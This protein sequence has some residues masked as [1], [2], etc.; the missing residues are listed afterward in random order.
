MHWRRKLHCRRPKHERQRAEWSF[1]SSHQRTHPTIAY[2]NNNPTTV[3]NQKTLP[4]LTERLLAC[5]GTFGALAWPRNHPCFYKYTCTTAGLLKKLGLGSPFGGNDATCHGDTHENPGLG[6]YQALVNPDKQYFYGLLPHRHL[7]YV[8]ASPDGITQKG[9]LLEMKC[10]Y[11]AFIR[12]N[13]AW[14][15]VAHYYTQ[16]QLNMEITGTEVAHFIQYSPPLI[17]KSKHPSTGKEHRVYEHD[18]DTILKHGHKDDMYVKPLLLKVTECTRNRAFI[19]ELM[20]RIRQLWR[21]VE[22]VYDDARL[23]LGWQRVLRDLDDDTHMHSVVAFMRMYQACRAHKWPL[24]D[25]ATTL[26]LSSTPIDMRACEKR[27]EPND[28]AA[29]EDGAHIENPARFLRNLKCVCDHLVKVGNVDT[30][31]TWWKR[32]HFML[33]QRKEGLGARRNKN[34]LL[35]AWQRAYRTFARDQA[36]PPPPPTNMTG[37][38]H[39]THNTTDTVENCVSRCFK[40]FFDLSSPLVDQLRMLFK[41]NDIA[42]RDTDTLDKRMRYQYDSMERKDLM[43]DTVENLDTFTLPQNMGECLYYRF[44]TYEYNPRKLRGDRRTHLNQAARTSSTQPYCQTRTMCTDKK[45]APLLS[46]STTN[47]IRTPPT[48]KVV[49]RNA[50]YETVTATPLLPLSAPKSTNARH[51]ASSDNT[52]TPSP[53]PADIKR[54]R[55]TRHTLNTSSTTSDTVIDTTAL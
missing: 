33:G 20:P 50:S 3:D 6:V 22:N 16:L 13:N 5:T 8:G 23:P 21:H 28:V 9:V 12:K 7:P 37:G 30:V 17:S 4:W 2:L 24:F 43:L 49:S 29:L 31:K 53:P 54:A 18:I 27:L 15:S 52:T 40:L 10:P 47:T 32:D 41:A 19:D 38:T 11:Y 46:V 44:G 39:N 55:H 51:H 34:D 48:P 45:V 35:K 1:E 14:P 26:D 25:F 36:P 42:W